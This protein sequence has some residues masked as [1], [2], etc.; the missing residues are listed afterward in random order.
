MGAAALEALKRTS[1][2]PMASAPA[3]KKIALRPFGTTTDHKE[4]PFMRLQKQP[5]PTA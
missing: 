3:A 5:K 1:R 4:L 2:Q